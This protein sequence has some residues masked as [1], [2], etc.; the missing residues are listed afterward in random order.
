M[1]STNGTHATN[2]VNGATKANRF[3]IWG[4]DG[5]V[6]G[7]LKSILEAQ[8]KDVHTTTIRMENRESVLAELDRVKPTHVLNAAGCTGRPNVDWCED[9]KEETMRSNVIGTIN[10]TDCC[11]LKG[12][13]CTAFA[14]GCIYEYD[15]KHPWDGPGYV[16]TDKSNF[17]GSFYSEGKAHVEEVS[18]TYD[19][20]ALV[21]T[22]TYH[23]RS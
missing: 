19:L 21:Q 23:P 12:I 16:E 7:H 11:F 8:G 20:W 10:L 2:D 13:H 4:G 5:W 15:E 18:F 6:A 9:H 22:L 17:S 3:L 1:A 14:T